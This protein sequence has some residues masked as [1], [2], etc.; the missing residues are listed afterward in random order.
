MTYRVVM[1][2]AALHDLDALLDYVRTASGQTNADSMEATITN[3]I[4]TLSDNPHRCALTRV[5]GETRVLVT[6]QGTSILFAIDEAAEEVVILAI[7][8]RGRD[9]STLIRSRR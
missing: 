7:G 1:T 2:I 8:H 6:R 5:D 3:A 4:P 9:I